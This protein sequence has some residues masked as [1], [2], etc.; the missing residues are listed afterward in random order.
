MFARVAQ[1]R[2]SGEASVKQATVECRKIFAKW[3]AQGLIKKAA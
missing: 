1:G 2:R 3:Q